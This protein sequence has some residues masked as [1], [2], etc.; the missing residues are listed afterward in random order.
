M[1][2]VA[3]SRARSTTDIQN[4][5][6]VVSTFSMKIVLT[7]LYSCLVFR[8]V[9]CAG[10]HSTNDFYQKEVIDGWHCSNWALSDAVDLKQNVAR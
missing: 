5:F 9:L 6:S 8:F 2:C 7:I 10:W 1:I 4:V 3:T